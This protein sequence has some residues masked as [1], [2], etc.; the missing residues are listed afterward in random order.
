MVVKRSP[1]PDVVVEV[2]KKSG[3]DNYMHVMCYYFILLLSSDN[4]VSCMLYIF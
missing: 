2:S 3:V 1:C 4:F